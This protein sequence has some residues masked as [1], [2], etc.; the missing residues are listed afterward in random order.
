TRVLVRPEQEHL[1][2][3][4]GH[5]GYHEI[6]APVMQRPQKPA[7]GLLI[8]QVLQT[9][10]RL[11]GRRDVDEGQTDAGHDL[12]EKTEERPAAEDIKPT[13]GAGRYRV[14]GGRGEQ[15]ADMDSLVDPQGDV[16]EHARFLFSAR[17]SEGL[18]QRGQLAAP[19]PQ[20]PLLDLV[21][22]FV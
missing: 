18:R 5:D 1:R 4:H 8:I 3:V 20:L 15:L 17:A 10:I 14:A 9:G 16:A 21:L 11:I 19:Y 6:G 13:A 2:H 12:N 22:I 7:K